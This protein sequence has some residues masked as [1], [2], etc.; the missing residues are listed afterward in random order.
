MRLMGSQKYWVILRDV[1][2]HLHPDMRKRQTLSYVAGMVLLVGTISFGQEWANR[3]YGVGIASIESPYQVELIFYASPSKQ[4]GSVAF[5]HAE[6][7][8]FTKSNSTVRSFG[9]MIEISYDDIGFPVLAVSPDSQWVKVSLDCHDLK[10]KSIGWI[11][12]R[13]AGLSVQSW[14][15]ILSNRS[16]LF[17]MKS[18]WISFYARPDKSTRV[19]PKLIRQGSSPN[20]QLY[21]K[22]V[23]GRWMQVELETPSSFCKT[24][25]DVLKEY[26]V[27]PTKQVVWIQFLDERNRPRIFYY[28]RGC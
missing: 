1:I 19:H 3:E 4:S 24:E 28:T 25:E 14:A 7:L 9:Q 2:R 18:D 10:N 17:F 26:G 12:K 22:Q 6:S 27:K 16:A 15:E 5:F 13:T 23:T 21:R 8:T 20:Y 11:P